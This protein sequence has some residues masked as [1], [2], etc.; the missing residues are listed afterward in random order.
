[1]FCAR[2]SIICCK[3]SHIWY[4]VRGYTGVHTWYRHWDTCVNVEFTW[5]GKSPD[6]LSYKVFL[7]YVFPRKIYYNAQLLSYLLVPIFSYFFFH[8]LSEAYFALLFTKTGLLSLLS[9]NTVN[10]N[11]VLLQL[12]HLLVIYNSSS[13]VIC[14]IL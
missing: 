12:F 3:W 14:V 9:K 2:W 6:F 8:F 1:L 7:F 10:D 11:K 4:Q 13:I 5:R